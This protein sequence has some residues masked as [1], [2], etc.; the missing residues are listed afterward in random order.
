MGNVSP[1]MGFLSAYT[2]CGLAAALLKRRTSGET[3]ENV[4][5]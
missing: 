1:Q 2:V 4:E 5:Q 3:L